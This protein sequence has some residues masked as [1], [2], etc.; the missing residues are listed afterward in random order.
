MTIT[1]CGS[2]FIIFGSIF[3]E[4][5]L[6]DTGVLLIF[7]ALCF[8]I[9]YN[10][11]TRITKQLIKPIAKPAILYIIRRYDEIH[12]AKDFTDPT[13]NLYMVI[14][15]L[16]LPIYMRFTF[17]PGIIIAIIRSTLHS[18]ANVLRNFGD[19]CQES[20]ILWPIAGVIKWALGPR[21]CRQARRLRLRKPTSYLRHRRRSILLNKVLFICFV[22]LPVMD[23]TFVKALQLHTTVQWIP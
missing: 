16:R 8:S 1:C 18:I 12:N 2:P 21:E 4:D 5:P 11:I 9:G 7:K 3:K 14:F 22:V 10:I 20:K 6:R 23:K 19:C 17:I 13:A 15:S